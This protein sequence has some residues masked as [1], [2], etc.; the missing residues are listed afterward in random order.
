MEQTTYNSVF[1]FPDVNANQILK[2]IVVEVHSSLLETE[3]SSSRSIQFVFIFYGL[4]RQ[5][6]LDLD[7][8]CM[9]DIYY[10]A[11]CTVIHA[12]MLLSKWT[13]L[14]SYMD[15]VNLAE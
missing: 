14:E 3:N 8:I 10:Y 9:D 4:T 13:E 5:Y 11:T 6:T 12:R 7:A 15:R 1:L 2:Y